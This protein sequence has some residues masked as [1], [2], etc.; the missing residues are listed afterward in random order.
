VDDRDV[1]AAKNILQ[2]GMQPSARGF[3]YEPSTT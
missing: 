1:N 2:A 3:N